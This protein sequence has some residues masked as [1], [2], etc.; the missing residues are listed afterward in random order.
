MM[1]Q[2]V[3]EDPF[4]LL[5]K[6]CE[7]VTYSIIN[8]YYFHG[9][10]T[11]DL[12]QEANSVLFDA[13]TKFEFEKGNDFCQF[14]LPLLENNFDML[15]RKE[16]THKRRINS[17]TLSLDQL[18]EEAGARVQGSSSA[19]TYPEDVT[20]AKDTYNNY[21]IDLSPFEK[22][23][24]MHFLKGKR[25]REIAQKLN[26]TEDKVGRAIYRCAKKLKNI[27]YY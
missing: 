6:A 25:K 17:D 11:S 20:I 5:V 7:P 10:E 22:K 15:V 21:I 24:F 13:A 27:I 2:T 16:Y 23:V 14:Y 18:V 8:K 4:N 12:A 26:T 1:F 9:Y 19:D 3:K